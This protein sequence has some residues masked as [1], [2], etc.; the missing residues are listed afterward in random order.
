MSPRARASAKVEAGSG[1]YV[2]PE[3]GRAFA[4]PAALGAHRSRVH[5]VAGRSSS[6]RRTR[7]GATRARKTMTRAK[8]AGTKRAGTGRAKTAAAKTRTAGSTTRASR[9]RA[10]GAPGRRTNSSRTS[11]N[12]DQLLGTLFPNGIPAREAAISRVNA[13][14]DEAERLARMR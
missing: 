14:L 10:A 4:R 9:K 8:G 6:A 7:G 3:C 2:C 12:R 11:V 13:W 1:E 5:G